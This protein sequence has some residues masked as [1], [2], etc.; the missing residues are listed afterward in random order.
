MPQ[1]EEPLNSVSNDGGDVLELRGHRR[2][3]EVGHKLEDCVE[4]EEGEHGHVL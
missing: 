2:N 3:I 4:S 1:E